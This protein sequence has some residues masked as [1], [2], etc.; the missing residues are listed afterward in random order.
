[1]ENLTCIAVD[2]RMDKDTLLYKGNCGGKWTEN[3]EKTKGPEHY[4][5]YWC[6]R[7]RSCRASG[8][9]FA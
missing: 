7:C 8:G 3:Y 4:M 2:G 5:K 9:G 6:N 1:M